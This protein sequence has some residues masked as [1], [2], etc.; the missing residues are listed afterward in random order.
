MCE[1]MC[2]M[3][4]PTSPNICLYTAQSN[5]SVGSVKPEANRSIVTNLLCACASKDG[6]KRCQ[7]QTSKAWSACMW[8]CEIWDIVLYQDHR[9]ISAS[10]QHIL[11]GLKLDAKQRSALTVC[12]QCVSIMYTPEHPVF[13]RQAGDGSAAKAGNL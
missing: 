2:Q 9:Q 4:V 5:H 12:I 6:T 3:I 1:Y 8:L 13:Q 10:Q 11:T 7:I